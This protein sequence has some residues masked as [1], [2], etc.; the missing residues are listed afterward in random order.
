[1]IRSTRPWPFRLGIT[2]TAALVGASP[3]RAQLTFAPDDPSGIYDIGETV[4]WTVQAAPGAQP[5]SAYRY[6]VR[7]DGGTEIASGTFEMRTGGARIETSLDQLGM[8]IVEVRPPEPD[9]QFGSRSTGGPGRIM[10]G[11]AVD[12]KNIRPAEPRP[13][14]FDE[15]WASQIERLSQIPMNPVI[16]PGDSDRSG[17]EWGT[18]RLNNINGAGV[19]AQWAKPAREGRFPALLIFQWASPPYSLQKSWATEHAANG[20]LVVN[21]EPHDVPPNM[22]QEYYDNLPA[23]VRNYATIGQHSRE[24]SHFLQMYLGDYRAIEYVA[25]RDDWDGR[26]LVVMGTSMGGQQSFAMAG[27]NPRV[28]HLIVHVPSG[29]D[30]T[31][32]LHG[33][34]ASYPN[35]NV[36]RPEV[37]ETAR[38]FD[39]ANFAPRITARS[40][41]SMGFIDDVSTPTGIWSVFNQI[42]GPKE[43]VPLVDAH[44]NH[45]ATQEQQV[46][47]TSRAAEWLAALVRGEE[48]PPRSSDR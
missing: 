6:T 37:Q 26:T 4:G 18:L 28:T 42:Q 23:L 10:L 21:V 40:L 13:A 15:F 3:V 5:T 41:V 16:T 29:A 44:H 47:Y 39:T 25:S 22:P 31:A 45:I 2:L 34:A 35:W 19:H 9:Q 48:P 38:Y 32:R 1:M 20:W 11:A 33:R 17:V 8:V 24:E 27:L 14:D 43:V 30:V 46:P 36:D 12:P 7:R